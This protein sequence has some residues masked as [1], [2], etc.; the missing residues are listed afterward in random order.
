MPGEN[1]LEPLFKEKVESSP[2]PIQKLNRRCSAQSKNTR[3]DF[4]VLAA[5]SALGLA[6]T[7]PIPVGSESAFCEPV[8]ATSTPHSSIRKSSAQIEDTPSTRSNAGGEVVSDASCCLV[9]DNADGLNSV[10]TVLGY[11][12]GQQIE[13][14]TSAP[15]TLDNIDV[16]FE[17]LL[18]VDPQQTELTN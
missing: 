6:Q 4:A 18:L 14:C 15:F 11:F 10:G 1:I 7:I 13:I 5:S 17:A 12:R 9:V 16:E 8:K 2:Q 3:T